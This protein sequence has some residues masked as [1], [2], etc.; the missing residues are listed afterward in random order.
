MITG[1]SLCTQEEEQALSLDQRQ[2]VH[3]GGCRHLEASEIPPTL[4]LSRCL[5]R[6]TDVCMR[7]LWGGG[8]GHSFRSASEGN[9][10]NF[11]LYLNHSET[12]LWLGKKIFYMNFK[13]N[14]FLNLVCFE[15]G[16]EKIRTTW[17]TISTNISSK[18]AL[19]FLSPVCRSDG[20]S[21]SLSFPHVH[22]LLT[23]LV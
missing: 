13:K 21:I 18:I 12:F 6:V 17:N 1:V 4:S 11:S 9:I 10:I 8:G 3:S 20:P 5:T 14:F 15:A 2:A 23:I 19:H 16:L 7:V 22:F